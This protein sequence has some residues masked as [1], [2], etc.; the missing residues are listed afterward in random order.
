M[1]IVN[2][3]PTFDIKEAGFFVFIRFYR[4]KTLRVERGVSLK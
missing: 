4:I 1:N 2:R 3:N